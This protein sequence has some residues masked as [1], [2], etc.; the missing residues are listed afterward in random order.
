MRLIDAEALRVGY[1]HMG[2]NPTEYAEESYA[3]GWCKGFN[4]GVDHCVHHVI[5]AQTVDAVPVIRCK[6]CK[7]SAHWYRNK[8]RC[9]LWA[10]SGIDVFDYG[11]CNYAERKEG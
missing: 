6:D 3:E 8:S 9:F 1:E 11:F 10:E 5:H 4:A 2:Y 7:H